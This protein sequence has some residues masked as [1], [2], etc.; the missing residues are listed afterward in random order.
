M[1]AASWRSAP[2]CSRRT[3][4]RSP[5]S[6][7]SNR[8]ERLRAGAHF[9]REGAEPTARNDEG[10][11]TSVAFSPTL[12]HWIGLGLL[13]G[14]PSRHGERVRAYDPVRGGDV[15]VEVC[16][17]VFYDPAGERLRG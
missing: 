12:G 8:K 15:A 16:N 17:P 3:G 14:G 13:A 7:R 2:G 10:Y 9:I 6:S 11:M 4:R 1:S 5:A